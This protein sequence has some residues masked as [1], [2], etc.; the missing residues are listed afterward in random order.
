MKF[1]KKLW[2][3]SVE[4]LK[5]ITERWRYE[6]S[7]ILMYEFWYGFVKPQYGKKLK[8]RYVDRDSFIVY[9]KTDVIYEDIAEDVETRF[10]TW[11]Y[12]LDRPLLKRM[13]QKSNWINE[14]WIRWK[15][16]DKIC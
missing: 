16:N 7:K 10:D 5:C 1:L 15:N 14:R 4:I 11:S 3:M 6:L 12:E 2:K 9:I 13:K 8:L